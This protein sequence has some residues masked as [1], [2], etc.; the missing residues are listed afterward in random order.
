MP[1]LTIN[2]KKTRVKALGA[3]AAEP[4]DTYVTK[5]LKLIPAEV[6]SV[7]LA[8]L[9]LIPASLPE[10]QKIAPLAWLGICFLFVII[11]RYAMT[12]DKNT[13]PDWKI[14]GLSVVSFVIWT[15]SM[16]GPWESTSVYISWLGG[17]AVIAWTFL[18]PYCFRD[19][20]AAGQS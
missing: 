1:L 16:G 20:A 14:I 19:E 5:L 3:P 10:S 18:V 9:A 7:Y 17:L 2:V 12:T 4:Y 13:S 8:G 6:I 15:Y 11:A